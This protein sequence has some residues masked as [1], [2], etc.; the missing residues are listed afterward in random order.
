MIIIWKK[1]RAN[2]IIDGV[3]KYYS[4][5]RD[6]LF[7]RH[8]NIIRRNRKRIAIKLLKDVANLSFIEIGNA[9]NCTADPLYDHYREINEDLSPDSY[10][11]KELKRE[12]I[13]I[14][15]YL[16]L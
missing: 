1:D 9:V 10:G 8:K 4:I 13:D 5:S 7:N 12:Y 3:C 16:N 6:E 11:E 14:L 15:Q 2:Y